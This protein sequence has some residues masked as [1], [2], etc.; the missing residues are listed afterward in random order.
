MIKMSY[1]TNNARLDTSGLS[2]RFEGPG[3]TANSLRDT[4]IVTVNRFL[5]VS[6]LEPNALGVLSVTQIKISLRTEVG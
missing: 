2:Q 1:T 4:T 6:Y 5:F 3:V